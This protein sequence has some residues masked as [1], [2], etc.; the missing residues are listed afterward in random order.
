MAQRT[1]RP[2]EDS[3]KTVSR[4]ESIRKAAVRRVSAPLDDDENQAFTPPRAPLRVMN[5]LLELANDPMGV[6]LA[7]LDRKSVV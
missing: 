6:V 2:G 5:I 1:P 7:R 4:K 3:L